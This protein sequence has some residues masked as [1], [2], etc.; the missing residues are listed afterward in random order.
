MLMHARS[1]SLRPRL[2][3]HA[4]RA[5]VLWCAVGGVPFTANSANADEPPAAANQP[6]ASSSAE[7]ARPL[8]TPAER[9]A[10]LAKRDA[11]ARAGDA[12]VVSALHAQLAVDAR[13]RALRVHDAWMPRRNAATA[14]FPQS[15]RRLEWNALNVAADFF[16]FQY[17]VASESDA[18]SLPAL[19]A[20]LARE[21]A[22][23]GTGLCDSYHVVTGAPLNRN[24]G[25]K[26]FGT[27]EYLKDG[28]ISLYERTGDPAVRARMIEVADAIL[29]ASN[30]PS[31]FGPIP[32]RDS[33][34]NGNVLQAF[35]RL[36][37][38]TGDSRYADQA[39]RV[40]DA[41]ILQ[42]FPVSGGVP[43]HKFD[44]AADRPLSSVV[45]LRD[46]GN[47][48]AVGLSEAFA[49][50]VT[51]AA[52]PDADPIWKTRAERWA[53]PIARMY[54]TLLT[55]GR[56]ADG[57]LMNRIIAAGAPDPSATQPCDNWGYLL[58]GAI[59]Y[60][61]AARRHGSP[62]V[63]TERLDAIL[64]SV[65][66]V[67]RALAARH[68]IVW[69]P[70]PGTASPVKS[71][72]DDRAEEDASSS[73]VGHHDGLADSVES[74]LYIAFHRPA[75]RAEL[76]AWADVE[77][78]RMFALQREDGFVSGDYLDGNF[79]RTALLY[80]DARAIA[81]P[82]QTPPRWRSRLHLPWDWPRI[83]SWPEWSHAPTAPS[84]HP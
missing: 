57:L 16:C 52:E 76:L 45:H 22:L 31:R 13:A 26:L 12:V 60:T 65:D 24:P 3:V 18:P 46:H 6:P 61:Q 9:T 42:M 78:A 7:S 25:R 62:T 28:L 56:N 72:D 49:L 75:L 77:I 15:P 27:T 17:A 44:Y 43:M 63:P 73:A 19:R 58:S 39:G 41:V 8:L 10:L 38:L 1:P 40:A 69:E 4:V 54:E 50:A 71:S 81:P 11:A 67:A 47:E 35:S 51:R 36:A 68:D 33:E 80:A 64:V 74:A 83:N 59:L 70:L 53:E 23:N 2:R 37:F 21:R 14:L 29:A 55:T 66:E 20:T 82:S 84:T 48:T 79:M 34:V 5:L 32:S 30:H